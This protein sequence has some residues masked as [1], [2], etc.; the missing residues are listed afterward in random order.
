MS[1]LQIT[2]SICCSAYDQYDHEPRLIPSCYHTICS[3]CIQHMLTKRQ[4]PNDFE[5]PL[6]KGIF[7]QSNLELIKFPKNYAILDALNPVSEVKVC[8]AHNVSEDQLCM[9]C[10]KVVCIKCIMHDHQDHDLKSFELFDSE[11]KNRVKELED[12]VS[13]IKVIIESIERVITMR[14][15]NLEALVSLKFDVLIGMLEDQRNDIL[16][17]IDKYFSN[18]RPF[19]LKLKEEAAED[20]RYI[21]LISWLKEI[22]DTVSKVKTC[23]DRTMINR[24]I[25]GDKEIKFDILYQFTK[26]NET[27]F[28]NLFLKNIK[29]C[30]ADDLERNLVENYCKLDT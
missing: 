11:V 14:R 24:D 3:Y 2:C 26:Y 15:Q 20:N 17:A 18:L 10:N 29:V 4:T 21:D 7:H 1:K 28:A 27:A 23:D 9:T 19:E 22:S 12:T 13:T 8:K 30:F 6:C 16:A 25:F 5:C